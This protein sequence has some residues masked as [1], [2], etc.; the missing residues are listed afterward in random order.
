MEVGGRGWR[1]L[2]W[3]GGFRLSA[4]GSH[5]IGGNIF[6]QTITLRHE[7]GHAM[8]SIFGSGTSGIQN[9]G[10]SVPNGTQISMDNTSL[11]ENVCFFDG[12]PPTSPILLP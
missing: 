2:A 5:A 8:N 1:L 3:P 6:S 11:V 7:L 10:S 12:Y 9:D 4:A